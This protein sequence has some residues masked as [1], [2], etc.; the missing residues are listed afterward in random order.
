MAS[1]VVWV[2][3]E[4]LHLAESVASH[5]TG[6]PA[7]EGGVPWTLSTRYYTADLVVQ[8]L[9]LRAA[10]E[11]LAAE[12]AGGAPGALLTVC[13]GGDR[14]SLRRLQETLRGDAGE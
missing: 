12:G 3:A 8:P 13:D 14:E 9:T 1:A 11:R 5:L 7:S 6:R 4:D 2:V 10:G